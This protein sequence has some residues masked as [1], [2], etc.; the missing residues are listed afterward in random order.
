MTSNNL[1]TKVCIL[2]NRTNKNFYLW[3]PD[4]PKVF[5][6]LSITYYLNKCNQIF[7][8]AKWIENVQVYSGDFLRGA[9]FKMHILDLYIK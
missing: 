7:L 4:L 6:N 2:G 8:L 5:E 3:L 9:F 1:F